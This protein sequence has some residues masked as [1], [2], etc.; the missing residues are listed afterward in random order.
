MPAGGSVLCSASSPLRADDAF[1]PWLYMERTSSPSL[2]ISTATIDWN[3]EAE[4]EADE[5]RDPAWGTGTA[6]SAST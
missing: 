1:E 4:E 3:E 6:T 5:D 2:L